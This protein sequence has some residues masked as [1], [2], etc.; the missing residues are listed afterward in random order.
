MSVQVFESEVLNVSVTSVVCEDG[1]IYFKRKMSPRL[2]DMQ[3][4][5]VLFGDMSGKKISLSGV[6]LKAN[7]GYTRV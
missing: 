1:E 6:S 5:M 3:I 2:W 4:Q 7:P